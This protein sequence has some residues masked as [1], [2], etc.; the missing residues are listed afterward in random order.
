MLSLGDKKQL[1]STRKTCLLPLL[2]TASSIF[3]FQNH[4]ITVAHLIQVIE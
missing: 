4:Y 1:E 2:T 3:I